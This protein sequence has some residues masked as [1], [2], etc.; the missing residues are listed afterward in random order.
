MSRVSKRSFS[1]LWLCCALAQFPIAVPALAQNSAT[2]TADAGPCSLEKAEPATVARVEDSF[3][4]VLDDGRRV[5]LAGL[6][7]PPK[8]A[9]RDAALTRLIAW[10]DGADVFVEVFAEAPDRWGKRPAQIVTAAGSEPSAPLL[11]VGAALLAEGLARYRPD[12][13]AAPCALLYLAAERKP[14]EA[15]QGVW[16]I[17][18]EIDVSFAR[19]EAL[20]AL[21]QS[22]G[23]AVVT[24]RIASVGETGSAYYLN[25]GLKRAGDFAVMVFKKNLAIFEAHGVVPRTLM[26][27]RVRVR[28]LIDHNNGPRMEIL[29]P[30]ALELLDA[31]AR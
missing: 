17:A 18:P 14:R 11:S 28:G 8:G 25:F 3:D 19:P 12:A 23:L 4:L 24:G 9:L 26:G 6:D 21:A 20:A 30:A 31:G 13:A 27:R 1:S 7:F 29:A 2:P 15:R 16:A 5:A 10:L 22:S